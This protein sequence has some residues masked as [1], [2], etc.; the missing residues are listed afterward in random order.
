M[1]GRLTTHRLL[2]LLIL[3]AND[4]NGEGAVRV[5]LPPEDNV[6]HGHGTVP[7]NNHKELRTSKITED[8]TENAEFVPKEVPVKHTEA[9][10]DCDVERETVLIT[11]EPVVKLDTVT[12]KEP[13]DE[14]PTIK[15]TRTAGGDGRVHDTG[16]GG[17]DYASVNDPNAN[18]P[19]P[20]IEAHLNIGG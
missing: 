4:V 10:G 8:N 7:V 13:V 20:D 12:A 15:L 5:N 3:P 9:Y 19:A 16:H 17:P 2:I 6:E 11:K 1:I 18:A 14:D